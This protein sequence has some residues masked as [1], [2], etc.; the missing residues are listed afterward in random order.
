[1]PRQ[2]RRERQQR[3]EKARLMRLEG[4]VESMRLQQAADSL[5]STKQLVWRGVVGGFARGVGIM[6]GFSLLGALVGY[7]LTSAIFDN[8]PELVAWLEK[9]LENIQKRM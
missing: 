2:A 7:I 9:M 1:M 6:L 5:L 4:L 8:L 3:R